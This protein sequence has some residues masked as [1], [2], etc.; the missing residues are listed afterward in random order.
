MLN[1]CD[2]KYAPL[3]VLLFLF[4]ACGTLPRYNKLEITPLFE[5][6][7]IGV[8]ALEIHH[9]KV[10]FAGREG[11]VGIYDLD[12]KSIETTQWENHEYRA[13]GVSYAAENPMLFLINVGSPA[14]LLS[15]DDIFNLKRQLISNHPNA[16]FD[17]LVIN[18][19]MRGIAIGDPIDSCMSYLTFDPN[20]NQ[21]LGC[22]QFPK[23]FPGEAALLQAIPTSKL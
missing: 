7:N 18:D 9:R 11:W 4:E 16:F 23:T 19:Y 2:I 8:R 12:K 1:L 10:F 13:I 21:L 20:S 17:A 15:G 22:E 14:Y 3:L 6:E 5:K